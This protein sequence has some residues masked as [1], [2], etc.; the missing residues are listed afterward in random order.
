MT[1]LS[2]RRATEADI[3]FIME[4][5]RKPGYDQFIGCYGV[6]EHMA[7]LASP[8]FAYL[9]GE[10]DD[11]QTLGFVILMDLNRRDGNACVKRIAVA[12]PEKGVGTPLLAG[13]VDFA[14][15]ETNAH[16]LWLDVVSGNLRA[17]AV[18]RKIG[19]IQEGVLREAALLPDGSRSDFLLMSM[20]RPEW[21]ARRG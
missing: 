2:L 15:L 16:R 10:D 5:E 19:F 14:F 12:S 20:L 11:G 4:T 7:Q 13:A 9:I 21:A 3:P 6:D 8:S 1:A 17:Q 18:Y